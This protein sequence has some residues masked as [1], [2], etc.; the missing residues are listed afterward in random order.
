M[1]NISVKAKNNFLVSSKDFVLIWL[2]VF[3]FFISRMIMFGFLNPFAISYLS[4]F[5][6]GFEFYFIALAIAIGLFTKLSG[7]Y[8]VKYLA[9]IFLMGVINIFAGRKLSLLFKESTSFFCVLVSGFIISFF[10]GAGNFLFLISLIEGVIVFLLSYIFNPAYKFLNGK[11]NS[12]ANDEL[13]SLAIILGSSIAGMSD[14]HIAGISILSIFTI[15]ILLVI[16]DNYS[17]AYSSM[18][19]LIIGIMLNLSGQIGYSEVII[20][21][22]AGIFCGIFKNNKLANIICLILSSSLIIL[23]IKPSLMTRELLL[24]SFI[25][26]ILFMVIKT[27]F[28]KVQDEN[29]YVDHIK[30]M[31]NYRLKSFA[32]SFNK[33]SVTFNNL[34]EKKSSLDRK[35]ISK[36]IDEI[37]SKSC[38]NCSMK[39]FCWENNF[40][41]TYQTVFSILNACEKKG[42]V[43]INDIPSSFRLNCVSLG[44][45]VENTNKLFEIYKINLAWNNKIIESREL[46]S[47]QLL[48]VSTIINNL[49]NEL[50]LEMRF[51]KDAEEKI[52]GEFM[53]NNIDFE[54][55]TAV[56]NKEDRYEIAV[57]LKSC[58]NRK[59]CNKKILPLINKSL[60]TNMVIEEDY[61][62]MQRGFCN[63]KFV[64]RQ[65]FFV[66]SAVSRCIK[67][68]SVESGD[69]YSV[70]ELKNGQCALV[71]SDG[72][73]SGSSAK[74]ESSAAVE[75]LE[76]FMESGFDK[77]TAMKMINSILVLKSSDD[78]FSTLDVCF[79]DLYSGCGEFIKTGASISFLFRDSNLQVI[80]SSSLPI[81]ILTNVEFEVFNKKF[82][83]GDIIIMMTDGVFDTAE[84]IHDKKEWLLNLLL[85]LNS[86]NPQD[87]SDYIL[88]QAKLANNNIIKDDMTILTARVWEKIK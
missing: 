25:S 83:D 71:L 60:D 55:V 12:L 68:N 59:F 22:T 77:N 54:S 24:S 82:R 10:A 44:R 74:I 48:G 84:N 31:V 20:L 65:K 4:L 21:G 58:G 18:F 52:V 17:S 76:D 57:N 66:T 69:C 73:G 86:N 3:G 49:A 50:N 27:D 67:K 7:V 14:V 75:L 39:A 5:L 88:A 87:I 64:E 85:S 36:L 8:F 61:C 34:A 32:E 45:F 81:G 80:K 6:G 41:D 40:Y 53:K 1:Q 2:I 78:S 26:I 37:A 47:Q 63:L 70:M 51:D 38:S 11:L 30:N 29:E 62:I 16:G 42:A 79:I 19:G 56:K 35:D 72:M 13:L 43:S 33:L 46:V 9:C 28:A 23:Y 15:F